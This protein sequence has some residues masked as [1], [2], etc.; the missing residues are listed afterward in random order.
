[1]ASC[2]KHRSN[3]PVHAPNGQYRVSGG[4]YLSCPAGMTYEDMEEAFESEYT[5]IIFTS[6]TRRHRTKD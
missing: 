5:I 6:I 3:K 4:S 2:C 1:M